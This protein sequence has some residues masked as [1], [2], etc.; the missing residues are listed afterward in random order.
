MGRLLLPVLCGLFFGCQPAP[1]LVI[2]LRARP[3]VPSELTKVRVV[4]VQGSVTIAEQEYPL[5]GKP[6][7]QTLALVSRG[8][9]SGR[10]TIRVQ[11]FRTDTIEARGQAEA[12]LGRERP[13]PRVSLVLERLC[14]DG[15]CGCVPRTCSTLGT[16]A[17]CGAVDDGCGGTIDCGVCPSGEACGAFGLNR[18]GSGTC[19]P[20]SCAATGFECGQVSD[21]CAG[22]L[23]CGTC[24]AP[25]SCGVAHVCGC[26]PESSA[27]FCARAGASCGPLT[28]TDNCGTLRTQASCGTCAVP[29][30][31]G[32]GGV[33]GICGCPGTGPECT[34]VG[35]PAAVFCSDAG[36]NCGAYRI[37]DNCGRQQEFNCGGCDVDAGL[38]CATDD[39]GGTCQ[40]CVP[41]DD[42]V[43]CDRR[44]ANCG[45]FTGADN[46]HLTRTVDCGTCGAAGGCGLAVA[47]LCQ[48]QPNLAGCSSAAQCCSG[49]CGSGLCCA[50]PGKACGDDADC[51]HG[52]CEQNLCELNPTFK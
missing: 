33:A 15:M 44:G 12:A 6:L 51:C 40:A 41:E 20:T 23:D 47:N 25:K 42:S 49:T 3:D 11:G 29:Q 34:C 48:C 50:A 17:T 27:A 7:P 14:V 32:G 45:S 19:T 2:E 21:G 37:K 24:T 26:T 16:A 13:A 28:A 30:S 9:I 46:C 39:F 4:V 8:P 36:Y 22:T 52:S 43:F 5:T 38:A 10:V 1:A 31:C 35:L 18:C